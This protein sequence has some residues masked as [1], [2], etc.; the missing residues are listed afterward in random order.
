M[1]DGFIVM[2][3]GNDTLDEV[4]RTAIVP[5][6]EGC[7][8][9][10][11][12]VDKHNSGGILKS[13]IIQFLQSADVIVADLT[14]ERPNVY[15]EVG[16]AMG[17]D[18][19]RNLILTVRH[20]HF[21][22][23]P[24]YVQG[25]PRIHFDLAGYDILGWH[26]DRLDEFRVGLE[27]RIRRRRA[28]VGST[29]GEA[30]PVWDEEWIE[31]QRLT[32][33]S[34]L[35]DLGRSGFM[36]VRAALAPPKPLRTQQELN[37]AAHGAQ[38]DTFG[39]PIAVYLEREDCRPRPRADGIFASVSTESKDSYDYWAIRK[40]CDVYIACSLFEDQR[41]PDTIFFDTRI[42]RVTEALLYLLRLY[43][44]LNVDPLTPVAITVRHGGLRGRGLS[45]ASPHRAPSPYV[46]VC[47]EDAA[48]TEIR[49]TLIG[50]ETNLVRHVTAIVSQLL[51]VFDFFELPE[52]EYEKVVND[53]VA[54]VIR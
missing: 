38:I 52:S 18:R 42:V 33:N 31:V 40:N 41:R 26:P 37:Q 51:T 50:I 35:A 7:G 21:S 53:F 8:L 24:D 49:D 12:R 32:A 1:A 19:F 3:I 22:D 45:V 15:L 2:Q 47:D 13:E 43:S 20:D 44:A 9:R 39:W 34:G 14:N 4:C 28:I 54:G 17:L 48:E 23:S 30:S 27:K 10:A 11:R 25:G 46:R 16:Y 29:A 6:I 5:A 36:E